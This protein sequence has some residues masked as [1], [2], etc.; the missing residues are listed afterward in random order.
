VSPAVA[1]SAAPDRSDRAP[2]AR[3]PVRSPRRI[4]GRVATDALMVAVAVVFLFPLLFA[5]LTSLKGSAEVDQY[6]PTLWPHTLTLSNYVAALQQA[7]L[8]RF[9]LNSLVQSGTITVAQLVTATL[10]AFAFSFMEFPYRQTLFF[11]FLA[12]LMI[13]GEVTLIP[14]YLT[15]R[16]LG[17]LDTYAALVS[18]F[19]AT[20][21]GTFLLRQFFLTIPREL[22]D[23][24]RID[25]ASRRRFLWAIVIPLSRPALAT[26]TIYAFLSSW[27]QYLW[28]LLVIN[29]TDMRTAQ[30]GLAILQ[31]SEVVAWNL[32][33][34]GVVL[35][36]LP[37]VLVFMLGYRHVV[38]GLTAGAVKG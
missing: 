30:V 34:A 32:V 35:I 25:G 6:P 13:P 20:A 29:S 2:A 10:A 27:N 14:N 3:R 16:A 28:P 23:A 5:V 19:L 36:I 31:S 1:T 37:T 26:L 11:T 22:Q 15:I 33:M 17:W 24:A 9:L 21:F 38:R 7:P 12:T 4:L 8:A 18:P